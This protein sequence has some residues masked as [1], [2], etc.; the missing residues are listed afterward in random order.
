MKDL[1]RNSLLF[2]HRI[3]IELVMGLWVL[4]AKGRNC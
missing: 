3:L 1:Y 4:A 2:E